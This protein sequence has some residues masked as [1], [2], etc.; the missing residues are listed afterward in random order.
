M[1][2][3]K[4]EKWRIYTLFCSV[5]RSPLSPSI[6]SIYAHLLLLLHLFAL[7]LPFIARLVFWYVF[8]CFQ[9]LFFSFL[10]F[11]FHFY[12]FWNS[13][14][15]L[16][17]HCTRTFVFVLLLRMFLCSEPSSV[18][19]SGYL[20]RLRPTPL[21][22]HHAFHLSFFYWLICVTRIAHS[23]VYLFVLLVVITSPAISLSTLSATLITDN[24]NRKLKL[25]PR[26]LSASRNRSWESSGIRRILILSSADH[27]FPP[28]TSAWQ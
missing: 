26:E 11:Y 22:L 15:S 18:Q 24:E 14:A 9:S 3:S 2:A 25:E 7:K 27:Y 6:T 1:A 17:S 12:F 16:L 5:L 13:S 8:F 4:G 28:T 21:L 10:F 23:L 20:N 19:L